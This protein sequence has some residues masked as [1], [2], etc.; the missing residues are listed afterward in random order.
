MVTR[1]LLVAYVVM[2][3]W[4]Y[5]ERISPLFF[6][7]GLRYREPDLTFYAVAIGLA[8]LISAI[9]PARIRK[10]SDFI[11]WVLYV[12]SV[13]PSILIPQYADII[14]VGDAIILALVVAASFVT[15][16]LLAGRGPRFLV[17]RLVLP[18]TVLV[19]LI[20][21]LTVACYGYLLYT[22][23]LSF[24]FVSLGWVRDLRFEYR[25]QLESTGAILGYVVRLQGNVINP[26]IMAAGIYR[27][28]WYLVATGIVGQLLIFSATGY[29]LTLLSPVAVVLLATAF[30]M[31]L[32]PRGRVI[33]A[34]ILASSAA[35]LLYDTAAQ[36]FL[37]TEIFVDR[38]VVTPG[39]LAA[40]Y[41][42]VFDGMP[43]AEWGYSFLAPFVDYP[44]S[45]TPAFIVGQAFS[46]NA[47]NSANANFFGDGFANLG[48]PGIFI[49]AIALVVILWLIDSSARHLPAAVSAIILLVP[50]IALVNSSTFTSF[51]S[52][53]YAAA[54][55]I[56][57]CLPGSGWGRRKLHRRHL[58]DTHEILENPSAEPLPP[59]GPGSPGKRPARHRQ[60]PTIPD[61]MQPHRG[62][63]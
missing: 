62:R 6:Y 28:S 16:V 27:R 14:P 1:V 10:P 55:V 8:I 2:L 34:G 4:V 32:R 40:A 61:Y 53:G 39:A 7:L 60:A 58:R 15:V 45:K 3:H 49:E 22:T 50:T 37:Y 57:A 35:A 33:L 30:R 63:C 31:N 26:L 11:L 52:N 20:A 29:R 24:R 43:K 19:M 42:K 59:P 13:I 9:M 44:Y 48:Y 47:Q 17:P 25:D 23:G 5:Q 18:P 21:T 12:M 56:M 36:T 38:L 41:V 46:G 51:L 54:I